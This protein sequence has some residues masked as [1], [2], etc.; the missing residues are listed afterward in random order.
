MAQETK[1]AALA[2]A[3]QL[4]VLLSNCGNPDFGQEA[5]TP[6]P[7][8]PENALARV[9]SLQ[10]ASAVCRKYI[11]SLELGGGNWSGGAITDESGNAVARVA[12]NGRIFGLDNTVLEEAAP[13]DAHPVPLELRPF[14]SW[15][16]G[17]HIVSTTPQETAQA[18]AP[19]RNR[20]QPLLKLC[21]Q[22]EAGYAAEKSMYDQ[23][24]TVLAEE[25][26]SRTG[27]IKELLELVG[28]LASTLGIVR[29]ALNDASSVVDASADESYAYQAELELAAADLER[30]RSY[31]GTP[32]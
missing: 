25:I 28:K 6:L 17:V 31:R 32:V 13:V 2:A 3:A 11:Q 10:H 21:E 5:S 8:T 26:T 30:V 14:R 23:G 7:G 27:E 19:E 1:P 4:W 20:G 18:A 9:S 16:S 22:I 24:M 29:A 15:L 12:Y